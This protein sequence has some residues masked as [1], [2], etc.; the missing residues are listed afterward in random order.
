MNHSIKVGMST[1]F[2]ANFQ[3]SSQRQ[4]IKQEIKRE[5]AGATTAVISGNHVSL[6]DSDQQ[7]S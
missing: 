4:K 3:T 6:N 1:L 2:N 5:A 7:D